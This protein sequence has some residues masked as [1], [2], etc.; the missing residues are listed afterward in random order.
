MKKVIIFTLF[1]ILSLTGCKKEE[2][3]K[4]PIEGKWTLIFFEKG[5]H[6]E[7]YEEGNINWEFNKYKELIVE[8]NDT[9]DLSE[10]QLPITNPGTYKYVAAE[11]AI[12]L[13]DVQ[14]AVSLENGMLI[15][16]H[17]SAAGG[18]QIKLKNIE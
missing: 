4:L 3:T 18:T 11:E 1:L 10:S 16:D 7:L 9:L 8:I 2:E 5:E 17:N 15:L 13:E 6:S 14:Y 12:S